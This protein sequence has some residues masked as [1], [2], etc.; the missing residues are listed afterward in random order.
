MELDIV[1]YGR[2]YK[3]TYDTTNADYFYKYLSTVEDMI[4]AFSIQEPRFEGINC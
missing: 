3:I 1:A 4:K 2:E